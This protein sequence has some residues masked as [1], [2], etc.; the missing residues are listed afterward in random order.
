MSTIPD[1]HEPFAENELRN[2]YIT[3]QINGILNDLGEYL[4]FSNPKYAYKSHL[5]FEAFRYNF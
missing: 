1:V 2:D 3:Q 5:I 4:I